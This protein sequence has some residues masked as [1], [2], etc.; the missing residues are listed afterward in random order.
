MTVE[1]SPTRLPRPAAGETGRGLPGSV[2]LALMAAGFSMF[3]T[4]S[5]PGHGQPLLTV[6]WRAD[7]TISR[8]AALAARIEFT[9]RRRGHQKS[10]G[11]S[12]RNDG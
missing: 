12:V 5:Q 11:R 10:H 9:A 8:E 6:W 2:V 4:W 3:V 1:D 7:R